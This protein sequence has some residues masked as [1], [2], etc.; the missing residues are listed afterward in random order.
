VAL[1]DALPDRL[2]EGGADFLLS[3]TGTAREPTT[4]TVGSTPMSTVPAPGISTTICPCPIATSVIV[5][6][7]TSEVL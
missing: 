2:A 4:T 1:R 5:A 7:I 3:A 6:S